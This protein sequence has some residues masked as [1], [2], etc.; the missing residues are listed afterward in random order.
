MA[1]VTDTNSPADN[2]GLVFEGHLPLAWGIID[3]L[4]G[5]AEL[6]KQSY[7]NVEILKILSLLDMPLGESGEDTPDTK[8][9]DIARLDL[10]V[11]MLLELVGQLFIQQQLMPD[12]QHLILTPD[13]LSWQADKKL[14]LDDLLQIELYCSL[15]YPRPLRLYGQVNHMN[16]QSTGWQIKV[17]FQA[18]GEALEEALE[19]FIFVHHRRAIAQRRR[20]PMS[21]SWDFHRR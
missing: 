9:Q 6:E 16:A 18:L 7:G 21:S 12:A 20:Q 5:T 17:T 14:D 11:N 4:P 15:K 1:K 2:R 8:S 19:S 10:K 13:S 3:S